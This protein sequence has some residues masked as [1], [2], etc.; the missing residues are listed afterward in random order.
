MLVNN[1][2]FV[3]AHLHQICCLAQ[4]QSRLSFSVDFMELSEDLIRTRGNNFKLIQ[5]HC[6]CDLRKFNFTNWVIPIWNSLSNHFV[7]A[8]TINTFKDRS[9]KFWSNHDVLCDYKS[10]LHGIGNR[11][12]IM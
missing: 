9:D 3:V 12:I 2:R 6:H 8:D 5:R 11:S 4:S 1:D 10:D 7:S